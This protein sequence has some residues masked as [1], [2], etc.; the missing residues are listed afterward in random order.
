MRVGRFIVVAALLIAAPAAVEPPASA[1]RPEAD[2]CAVPPGA[3]PLLPAKLL[4]GMGRTSM[5]VTTR[6]EPARAFFNQGVS[7]MHSFW[8][9]ESERSFLQAAALDPD[10]AMAYWGISVSAAGDYRPAF[11]LLRDPYDGGRGTAPAAAPGDIQRTAGGAAVDPRIRAREAI[12]KAMSLR[13]RVSARE[14]L[15][16][17][18][19][20]A[21][22]NPAA[23]SGD[24]AHIGGLRRLV[25]EYPDDLEA[26]S[27]LGLALL[28]GYDPVTKAPRTNTVE[29]TTLLHEVIAT[30]DDHFG[31]HHYL[32]HGWEGS[33][34]PQKAWPSCKRYPELVP[35]IPHALHMP[36][37]IFAQ[38]DRIDD[39][40]E[41][42]AQAANNELKWLGAD[43]L[44]PNG[45]H[46]HNVHFLVHSL[47]LEGRFR[48][49]MERVAH[50]MSFKETP[51]ERTGSS[52]RVAY[53]Q[54]YYS[55]VKTLV[56][57]ERWDLVLDGTTIPTHD[58]PEQHAWRTWAIGLGYAA[59]GRLD[60]AR[61]IGDEMRRHVSRVTATRRPLEIAALELE[62]TI[63]A[64]SGEK[65][66]GYEMFWKAADMEA[67][68]QYT[69]PPAYPRPVVEALGNTAAALGDPDVAEKA[70][71]A[72]LGREPG[73]GRAYFGLAFALRAMNRT[74]EALQM[75]A[76]GTRA[77]DRADAELTKTV[78]GSK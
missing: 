43:V 21:R 71:R 68:L 28:D 77:W 31:A 51:R 12:A 65:A 33:T 17:E 60:A 59:Q 4:P 41:A 32:I 38:S 66:R 74:D 19:E 23:E 55:L 50:L 11:Q 61:T 22:R 9:I 26:K 64:R 45:H 39:A 75:T 14:R 29:G 30:D 78:P 16:I 6:S 36:G 57:F 24:A 5:P 47:N 54:G 1:Q 76:A 2:L 25:A 7:Q 18:A 15:Y 10:M 20:A 49:S 63:L 73:S 35:N 67:A 53:R 44:Y 34:T 72:A 3:Q 52:Q 62:A 48:E 13:D 69:E 42:F 70:F 8:F 56:R 27:M 37:H 58:K 40:I 46:G